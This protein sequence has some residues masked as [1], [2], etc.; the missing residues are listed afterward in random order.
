MKEY[1]EKG[2]EMFFKFK[3]ALKESKSIQ[4][5]SDKCGFE[6]YAFDEW[7]ESLSNEVEVNLNLT[8]EEIIS[9]IVAVNYLNGRLSMNA[10]CEIIDLE[11]DDW[12]GE[13]YYFTEA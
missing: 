8:G 11:T 13:V 7:L 1:V 5:A 4:E 3:K 6:M 10:N 12:D 9:V 2:R